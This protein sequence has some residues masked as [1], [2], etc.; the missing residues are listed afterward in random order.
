M[1]DDRGD[2]AEFHMRKWG[3]GDDERGEGEG[4]GDDDRDGILS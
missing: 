1:R 4:V 2:G 3:K